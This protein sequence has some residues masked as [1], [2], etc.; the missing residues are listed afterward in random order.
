MDYKI[1]LPN[2]CLRRRFKEL[3][4]YIIGK[5]VLDVGCVGEEHNVFTPDWLHKHIA[6][7]ASYCLG[8][9]IQQDQINRLVKQGY[10]IQYCDAQLMPQLEKEPSFDVVFIGETLEHLPN[11]GNFL[12]GVDRN[13]KP[14]GL[15]IITTPNVFSVFRWLSLFLG[16]PTSSS[17]HVSWYDKS[18]LKNLLGT[19]GFEIVTF[20]L[21][22]VTTFKSIWFDLR[23]SYKIRRTAGTIAGLLIESLL[24]G[25][26][27]KRN[28]FT[29]SR[30][31]K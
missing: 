20:K 17:H 8:L 3:E 28:T 7:V 16:S 11:P 24:P 29:V 22:P 19:F 26:I 12:L 9:D 27:G 14:D 2:L 6:K 18:T 25:R 4:P 13:L 10:N 5:R 23:R 15:L 21:L 30:R 31:K 1:G